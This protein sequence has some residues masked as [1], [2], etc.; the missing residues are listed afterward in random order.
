MGKERQGMI[1][2]ST[3]SQ[4]IGTR[5]VNIVLEWKSREGYK[6]LPIFRHKLGKNSHSFNHKQIL[7]DIISISETKNIK[8]NLKIQT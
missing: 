2:Q 7:P 8:I 1:F 4:Q 6:L 5:T 3:N